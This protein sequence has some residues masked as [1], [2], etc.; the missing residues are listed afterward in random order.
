M[1]LIQ[2]QYKLSLT[3]LLLLNG[4]Q[5]KKFNLCLCL[6]DY[7]VLAFKMRYD[8]EEEEDHDGRRKYDIQL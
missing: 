4:L 7:V 3:L 8:D 5:Q 1:H 2:E 6:R